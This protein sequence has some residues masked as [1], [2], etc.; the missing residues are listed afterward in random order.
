MEQDVKNLSD[1]QNKAMK[2]VS[3]NDS[4]LSKHHEQQ[5]LTHEQVRRKF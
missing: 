2:P 5:R 1:V 4:N 3:A